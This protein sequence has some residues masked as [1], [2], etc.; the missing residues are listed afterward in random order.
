MWCGTTCREV[1]DPENPLY[2]RGP[3]GCDGRVPPPARRWGDCFDGVT[4]TTGRRIGVRSG[5]L[6]LCTHVRALHDQALAAVVV[7]QHDAP[8]PAGVHLPELVGVVARTRLLLSRVVVRGA[9]DDQAPPALAVLDP[10]PLTLRAGVVLPPVLPEVG[11]VARALH[12]ER[13]VVVVG[14]R[15]ATLAVVGD[16]LRERGAEVGGAD[17]CGT[18]GTGRG[19]RDA[20]RHDQCGQ[21]ERDSSAKSHRC[22][23]SVTGV[24][25]GR[26]CPAGIAESLRKC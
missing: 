26:P 10:E 21:Q 15:H 2:D 17:V 5:L 19:G 24:G 23:P 4:P 18:R 9:L 8:A 1:I 14:D 22:P 25:E 3:A 13:A 6:H 20:D 7:L 11:A 12:H 16:H